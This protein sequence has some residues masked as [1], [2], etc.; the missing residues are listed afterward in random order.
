MSNGSC[1]DSLPSDC[2]AG[3]GSPQGAG[4]TCATATCASTQA[5]CL[6]SG[7][8]TDAIPAA[9]AAAGGIL[10]GAGTTCA[11]RV[12][13]TI[14]ACC[15][16]GGTCLDVLPS[17]C[18]TAGGTP[19]GVRT[20]CAGTTCASVQACCLPDG[21]CLDATPAGCATAGGTLRGAGTSCSGTTCPLP[22]LPGYVPNGSASRPGTPFTVRKG[23][24]DPGLALAWSLSCSPD[25]VEYTVHEGR[26]GTWYSHDELLCST[27]G[28]LVRADITPGAG[29]RYYL[30]VPVTGVAEGSY[31]VDSF[32][33]ERP[34]S[35]TTCL[36][37]RLLGCR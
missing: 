5:C 17:A 8:C 2:L 23:A 29:N 37:T 13:P 19:Q 3:G 7:T 28:L 35:G 11:G 22:S 4:T 33:A 36:G 31:G 12:C 21:T 24:V 26:I 25:A 34:P 1:T 15:L 16:P 18:T 14:Q 27:G 20:T 32:G 30:V 6:S 9:C 10:Q